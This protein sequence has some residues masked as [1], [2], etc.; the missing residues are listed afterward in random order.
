[1]KLSLPLSILVAALGCGAQRSQVT[2]QGSETRPASASDSAE[3]VFGFLTA[4]TW[5]SNPPDIEHKPAPDYRVTTFAA[6]GTWSE[7]HLTDYHIEPKRGKWNLQR[8]A[9]RSETRAEKAGEWFVCRDDGQRHV[10]VMNADGTLTLTSMRLYPDQ[11][12]AANPR[13]TAASL[14]AIELLDAVQQIVRRLTAQTWE[15]ANDLDLRMEPTGVQFDRDWTFAATYRGGECV[16]RGHWY[17]TAQEISAINLT[18][19]CDDRPG[20]GGDWLTAA[21]IDERRIVVNHDLYLPQGTRP[22][23]GTIWRLFGFDTVA[24]RID[25]D[26]PIGAEAAVRFDVTFTNAHDRPVKLERFSLTERFDTY[27]RDVSGTGGSLMLPAEIAGVDLGGI[28][29]APGQSHEASLT[30][31]FSQAG[32][33]WVYFNALIS[34]VTQNWDFHQAHE[35]MIVK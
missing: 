21:V 17:A 15:R 22:A 35:M 13:F 29:L 3:E 18:G 2:S 33:Q 20:T 19:G 1:M 9:A 34:G 26:M 23:R 8:G 12:L 24:I 5:R 14:P 32:L 27:G 30:A 11:P 28:E 10:V 16:S 6:D 4:N 25:Y 7:Q 31:T